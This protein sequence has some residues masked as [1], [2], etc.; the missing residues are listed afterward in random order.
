MEIQEMV[1][2]NAL[3]DIY[4]ALLTARQREVARGYYEDDLSLAELAETYGVSRNAI[5]LLLKRSKE[6]LENYERKLRFLAKNEEMTKLLKEERLTKAEL[7]AEIKRVYRL[8]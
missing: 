1:R 4:G 3:L 8:R 2:L 7:S 5:F 6:S